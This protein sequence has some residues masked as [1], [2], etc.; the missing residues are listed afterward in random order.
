M[1]RLDV[2]GISEET[3]IEFKRHVQNKY[4]KLHTVFGLEVEKALSE[5]LKRQEE[6][7]TG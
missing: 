4:G 3:L 1:G 6:M 5:Y 2:R 7:D